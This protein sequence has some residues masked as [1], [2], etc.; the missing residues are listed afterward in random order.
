MKKQYYSKNKYI[1]KYTYNT[2][3]KTQYNWKSKKYKTK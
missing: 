2:E 1:Y 3:Y